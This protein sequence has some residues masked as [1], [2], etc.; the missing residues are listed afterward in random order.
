MTSI[1]TDLSPTSLVTAIKANLYAFFRSLGDSTVAE[2]SED[3]KA[4]RWYTRLPHP[5]F[6]G[7]LVKQPAGDNEEPFIADTRA[8]FDSRHT[9]GHSIWMAP[10]V[11]VEGWKRWLEPRGYQYDDRTPGMALDL[12]DLPKSVPQPARLRIREVAKTDLE[13]WA[14]TFMLGYEIPE[15]WV[16]EY[17]ALMASL[18]IDLPFRHYLGTLD[19]TPVAASTLFLGAGVAGIYSVA[20]VMQARGQGIGSA[21][22]L[23]PLLQAAEM[24]YRAGVLQSSEIGFGV[25]RR[26]GFSKLCTID[27]FYLGS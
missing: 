13:V 5:W 7:V 22:T 27:A 24:G 15:E 3:A 10:E 25:Y 17:L 6:S 12:A 18:G 2:F 4:A 16:G 26:L 19:D 14:H 23:L 8:Y 20:T 11:P 1:L 9:N 21:M